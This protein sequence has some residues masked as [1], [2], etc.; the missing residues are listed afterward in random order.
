MKKY[1]KIKH[2]WKKALK[3]GYFIG[4]MQSL[5]TRVKNFGALRKQE[6]YNNFLKKNIIQ[7]TDS[8]HLV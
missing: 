4:I 5:K 7:K 1:N 2:L 6:H 3:V 8:R